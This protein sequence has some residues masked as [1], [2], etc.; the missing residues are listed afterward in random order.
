[1]TRPGHDHPERP[2]AAPADGA[3]Q[4]D[5]VADDAAGAWHAAP[6][7]TVL[8]RLDAD[9][10]AGLDG[11]EAARRLDEH[12]PNRLRQAEAVPA[13]R[14]FFA[15]FADPLIYLLLAAV[16]IS[17]IAWVAEGAEGA[18]IDAIVILVIIALNAVIGFV[19]EQRASQAVAALQD[20]TAP[21][22]DVIRDGERRTV[23]SAEL[24]PGDLVLLEEGDTVPADARLV[25]STS[26]L[27]AEAALTGESVPVE[28][29]AD[30]VDDP[31][32]ALA[33]RTSMVYASC[34]VMQ[35]V[36]RAVVVETGMRTE[37]GRIAELLDATEQEPTPLE[38]EIGG[39]GK[40]LTI[41]V[42]IVALAVMITLYAVTPDH[43]ASSLVTILLLGVSLAVAAVPEGL[44]AILSMVLA[45]GVQRMAK[46]NAIV[47]RL[48]SV[49]TLGSATVICSD[50]TGTLTR[51]EMTI[52]VVA[53]ADGEL[54]IAALGP[55]A[56]TGPDARALDLAREVL[57]L[58]AVANNAELRPSEWDG[59]AEGYEG[60]RFR[61][62]GD[63]TEAAFQLALHAVER[64]VPQPHRRREVPFSSDRKRMTVI[65]DIP[66]AAAGDQGH[67]VVVTKG[68]PEVVLQRCTRIRRPEGTAPLTA[69]DR[70]VIAAQ[71]DALS[72]RAYRTL[73]V[74][75]RWAGA[76]D[77]EADD[78]ALE[79]DLVWLG[80]V[81]IVDPPRT[82]AAEAVAD[83][84][85]AGIR[86]VMITGDHPT[87][88]ARI[89]AD[90]GI[91]AGDGEAAR[92]VSGRELDG[93]DDAGFAAAVR[94]HSV[95]ARVAPE[96]KLRIVAALKAQENVVAMTGDGVNDAPALK[97][98]DI[99]VA[100]GRTGTQVTREAAD[101]ILADDNFATIVAAVREGRGIFSN[102][103]K[104]LRYLLSSNM[105][106]VLTML[107][108]V[109]LGTVLG[110]RLDDGTVVLPLLAT[111][112]LWIN[113]L[114][115]SLPALALGLDPVSRDV[116]R[117]KPRRLSD[118]V[119]DGRMWSTIAFVGT[120]MAV[121]A[122]IGFDWFLPGG[123]IDGPHTT[124]ET[125]ARTVAF[126]VLVLAQLFNVLNCRS[127]L[128][129]A[130][131]GLFHNRWLWGAI[132]L[133][134][135]LQLAVVYVP[136]LNTAFGTVP[137]GLEEWLVALV[138]ASS[139]L[140]LDELRKIVFRARQRSRDG[141]PGAANRSAVH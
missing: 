40:A 26:L 21:T 37:V 20:L 6:A 68:A 102:I 59:A 100:M 43:S 99:G 18:P 8:A 105:G 77:L 62:Y 139:V 85:A 119:I 70:E 28:K 135:L 117:R 106:E 112:I 125:H 42:I 35:G 65:A 86:V 73:A 2:A 29:S 82:E 132:G 131:D 5:A 17:V 30:P 104:F 122:L 53:I 79:R 69:D 1:M 60:P 94:E 88:A 90:L 71:V 58:G 121:A 47:T 84:H 109:V 55:T 98:A 66:A 113:L 46:R 4:P 64:P 107:L 136:W 54:P 44:P 126:T 19:Q 124:D 32:A 14:R 23:P 15:Q 130:F 61:I 25:S 128:L 11:A 75:A 118:R 38:R 34:A 48:N 127:E 67:G 27:I 16:V 133:S 63:P 57:R 141:A 140:W 51:N 96:H 116:M 41:L 72:R 110:L 52:E 76:D 87:T 111:Q 101:M 13:W 89:A 81:G 33:D 97:S 108:G 74:A 123:L 50:K 80:V 45:L 3:A 83:A 10:D 39:V 22:A 120:V 7:A 95:F 134:V 115:D 49:E 114:T 138:L 103:R 31:D 12:G 92:A 137:L 9:A 56:P 36:G 91:V 93:L 129:S 24:V 78:E